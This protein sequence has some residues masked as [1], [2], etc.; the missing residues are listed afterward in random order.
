VAAAFGTQIADEF[1][2]SWLGAGGAVVVGMRRALGVPNRGTALRWSE[3]VE[4]GRGRE[5]N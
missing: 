1:D 2:V 5:S 4:T 3:S